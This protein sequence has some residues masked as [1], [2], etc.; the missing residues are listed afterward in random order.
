M[1]PSRRGVPRSSRMPHVVRAAA[2]AATLSMAA[3]ASDSEHRRQ[4]YAH[5]AQIARGAM[6]QSRAAEPEVEDDGLPGQVPPPLNRRR[7]IDDPREPY[8]PNYGNPNAAPQRAAAVV[9]PQAVT[10]P[11]RRMAAN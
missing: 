11:V 2:L 1:L 9:L 7:E 3:C 5:D 6:V 8:S 4:T 10:Q